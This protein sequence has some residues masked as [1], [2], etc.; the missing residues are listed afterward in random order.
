MEKVVDHEPKMYSRPMV[1]SHQPI[2][3]ETTQSC[4]K[5]NGEDDHSDTEIDGI[6]GKHKVP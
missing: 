4:N 3:F 1:V 6:G 5:G 2:R